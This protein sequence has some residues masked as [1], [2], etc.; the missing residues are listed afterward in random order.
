MSLRIAHRS[1]P[2]RGETR[3]GDAV[4]VRG[5]RDSLL[6]AIVDALGHGPLAADA[7]ERA[8]EFLE[9]ATLRDGVRAI[10]EGLHDALHASRGAAATVCLVNPTHLE[11]AGIGNVAL[12]IYGALIAFVLTPGIVGGR[13]RKPRVFEGK[14]A[15]GTRL[16]LYS[17]GIRPEVSEEEARRGSPEESCDA[18]LRQHGR[19]D[20]DASILIGDVT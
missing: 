13:R 7:A 3:S 16:L 15:P 18:I 17:D 10:L 5:E 1:R 4:V 11:A 2:C 6:L 8:T 9:R 20:D 19:E 12:R 14:P